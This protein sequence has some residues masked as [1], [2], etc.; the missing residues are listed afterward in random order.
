MDDTTTC[1]ICGNTLRNIILKDKFL[2]LINKRATFVERTCSKGMNHSLQIFTEVDGY[3]KVHLL[4][5]SLNS[6]YSRF[7]EIDFHNNRCKISCLKNNI[8][9]TIEIPKIIEPDFPDLEKLKE[10]V[11]IYVSFS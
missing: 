11:G 2:H 8:P 10:K 3:S 4:K 6:K 9:Y 7:I 1:P 5:V